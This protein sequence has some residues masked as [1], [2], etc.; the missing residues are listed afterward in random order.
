MML[1]KDSSERAGER[2]IRVRTRARG[3]PRGQAV[4]PFGKR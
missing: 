2:R 3:E 1:S 4:K